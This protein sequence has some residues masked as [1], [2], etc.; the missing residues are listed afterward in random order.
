M[1]WRSMLH[2]Q[3]VCALAISSLGVLQNRAYCG[4]RSAQAPHTCQRQFCTMWAAWMPVDRGGHRCIN[5]ERKC[6][7]LHL[8]A[9]APPVRSV[10][11]LCMSNLFT[12]SPLGASW[13]EDGGGVFRMLCLS[14]GLGSICLV[15][16]IATW[17]DVCFWHMYLW[18]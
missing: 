14:A 3:V 13:Q 16:T 8:P 5:L 7:C 12:L 2:S 10:G 4:A 9:L 17:K 15:A 18:G 6:W 11:L 1:V